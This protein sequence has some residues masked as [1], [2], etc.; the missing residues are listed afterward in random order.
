M[1][2]AKGNTGNPGGRRKDP[3]GFKAMRTYLGLY[4]EEF[5]IELIDRALG[6]MGPDGTRDKASADLKALELA[7]A[8]LYGKPPA[9]LA[10]EGGSGPAQLEIVRRI[11]DANAQPSDAE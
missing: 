7:M 8:Y 10:G 4:S 9:V 5:A 1:A 2:F 6:R 3:E 11:I